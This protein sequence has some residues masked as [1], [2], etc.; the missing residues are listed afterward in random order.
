MNNNV[1]KNLT[2]N[3]ATNLVSC[4]QLQCPSYDSVVREFNICLPH[5]V[6]T[7]NVA[8]Y[9]GD[10]CNSKHVPT[11]GFIFA[12]EVVA[13]EGFKLTGVAQTTMTDRAAVLP[14]FYGVTSADWSKPIDVRIIDGKS[15]TTFTEFNITLNKSSNPNW[16]WFFTATNAGITTIMPCVKGALDTNFMGK[17]GDLNSL[18]ST[19]IFT[20]AG[21]NVIICPNEDK[22]ITRS[23]KKIIT[24]GNQ[25]NLDAEEL[26]RNITDKRI[27]YL[28]RY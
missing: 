10:N 17:F 12:S 19:F 5:E 14:E 8:M 24:I 4:S 7:G 16:P 20:V 18:A 6:L 28:K 26:I 13:T 9:L 3:S 21:C 23:F 22:D 11:S 15:I 1:Y 27:N 2:G 25:N